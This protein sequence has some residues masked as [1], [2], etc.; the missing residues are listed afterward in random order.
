MS[1]WLSDFIPEDIYIIREKELQQASSP[2]EKVQ[3]EPVPE[4]DVDETPKELGVIVDKTE[5]TTYND[6]LSAILTSIDKSVEQAELIEPGSQTG[7]QFRLMLDFT[8]AG[9]EK[10]SLIGSENTIINSDTLSALNAD[11][12]L[13]LKLWAVLK[14]FKSLQKSQ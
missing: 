9:S 14:E 10:Y 1:R 13:K 4:T 2:D 11:R 7:V 3:P 8:S 5:L 12:N 6:L